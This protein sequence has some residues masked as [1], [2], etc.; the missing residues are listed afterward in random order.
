M[1]DVVAKLQVDSSQFDQ[2][3]KSAVEQMTKM[4]A[5]VRRTGATFAYADKEELEFLQ[6]LGQ[7]QT[8][9]IDSSG[10]LKELTNNSYSVVDTGQTC[11]GPK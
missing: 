9:A 5:E 4:E 2:K 8:K 7:M 10:K 11:S 6:S 3:L 1:A